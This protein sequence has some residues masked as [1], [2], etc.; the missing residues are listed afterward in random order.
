MIDLFLAWLMIAAIFV[1]GVCML[2]EW[3]LALWKGWNS[4]ACTRLAIVQRCCGTTLIA[5]LFGKL[6]ILLFAWL[7]GNPGIFAYLIAVLI[8]LGALALIYFAVG[9]G[10]SARF[11]LVPRAWSALC[12]ASLGVL[13]FVGGAS[14]LARSAM[15]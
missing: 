14:V 7:F 12:L 10:L 5:Y 2:A 15:A 3:P 1:G 11:N 6:A 4:T 9:V 8:C 13:A